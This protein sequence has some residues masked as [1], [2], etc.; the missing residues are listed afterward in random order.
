M[1]TTGGG[2][3][4]GD[5][6]HLRRRCRRCRRIVLASAIAIATVGL[7]LHAAIGAVS[8]TVVLASGPSGQ[9]NDVRLVAADSAAIVFS[10]ADPELAA[11]TTTYVQ[12]RTGPAHPLPARFRVT[13]A[14][15]PTLVGNM[16]GTY[17]PS[18]TLASNPGSFV[19]STVDGSVG[20][21]TAVASGEFQGTSADGYLYSALPDAPTDT[22]GGVH[23]YDVNLVS[24]TTTDLGAVPGNP[25]FLSAIASAAGV[26]LETKKTADSVELPSLYYV[27]Y[28]DPN[29][30]VQLAS[31]VAIQGAPVV[32]ANSV[33]WLENATV[34][35]DDQ[36]FD[37]TATRVVRVTLE[38]SAV[39]RR[40]APNAYEVAVTAAYTGVL[41][42]SPGDA[43]ASLS[44][45]AT[46]GG[47]PAAY[48]TPVGADLLSTGTAF[49]VTQ[50]GTPE[51]A[52]VYTLP[53]AVGPAVLRSAAGAATL[54]ASTISV[55]SAR[56]VWR[57]N[58]VG[59]GL[60]GR[61]L[62]TVQTTLAA[63]DPSVISSQPD[64][65]SEE[66]VSASGD[67]VAYVDG[68]NAGTTSSVWLAAAGQAPQSI[69][70]AAADDDLTLSG[71][72]L[73]QRHDDGSATLTDLG[74]G[75]ASVLPAP[76]EPWSGA[77]VGRTDYQL[78][79]NELAW[80]ASDGSVWFKDL[81]SG[82]SSE[83]SGPAV[84]AGEAVVG[85]VA[86]AA[87]IVAW[88][89]SICTATEGGNEAASNCKS[90]GLRYR[91]GVTLGETYT[92]PS[93]DPTRI[94][95]SNGYLAFDDNSNGSSWVDVT[96]LYSSVIERIA[97]LSS[98]GAGEAEF[99]ISGSMLGWIGADNLPHAATLPHVPA[100][101]WYLGNGAV[102]SSLVTDGAHRWEAAF[103]ASEVLTQCAVNI[104]LGHT[105]VRVLPCDTTQ[106]AAG[107][108]LVSWD[109]RNSKGFNVS[110]GTYTW[111]L[112]G[113]N[114]DG[115][116]LD[117]DGND[118][119]ITGTITTTPH[120]IVSLACTSSSG[121]A[122]KPV[123]LTATISGAGPGDV[124]FFDGQTTIGTS[125]V[126]GGIATLTTSTLGSA[127]HSIT[128]TFTPADHGPA[129]TSSPVVLLLS[130]SSSHV[131]VTVVEP[132][133]A[134]DT[135]TMT[136]AYTP[137]HPLELGALQ[138]DPA[139]NRL[140]TSV[141]FG[142]PTAA[143]VEVTDSRPGN[144]NWTVSVET[145]DFTN[146]AAHTVINSQNTGITGLTAATKANS[147][148][149][150]N[151]I[152]FTN[153]SPPAVPLA[154]GV[155]GSDGLGGEPHQLASTTNGGNGTIGFYGLFTLEAPTSTA[156]GAYQGT[157]VFTIG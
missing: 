84:A 6:L 43:A 153:V 23:I 53:S 17:V 155:V 37:P 108:A 31:S 124:A 19:Y 151:G 15:P 106:M 88:S 39:E 3:P 45:S 135:L 134:P 154:A 117:A 122:Y 127:A 28:A 148:L 141:T 103:F 138:L 83:I 96:P 139:A 38:G 4:N 34:Y 41:S 140:A 91:N 30:F 22:A 48:E 1:R 57:D 112:D 26:V 95:L 64:P 110:P 75:T 78:W 68:G 25:A 118:S 35:N 111:T 36:S 125:T 150:A 107:D 94:Q 85:S 54:R 32:G 55:S 47:Q 126:S 92:V 63:G 42:A 86:V 50:G 152:T 146:D 104:S 113:A 72:R 74:D 58:G 156:P 76:V 119:P 145:S 67:R 143:A 136:T 59:A 9:P 132:A 128:A 147:L 10:V 14:R 105:T 61:T 115:P 13:D 16:L 123:T 97:A 77:F 100:K 51:T 133:N 130:D 62:S 89:E 116:L 46:T 114:A 11:G 131:G 49:V 21:T 81:L 65:T 33:A 66:S 157:I 129:A 144:P 102:T 40:A 56:V 93:A 29:A 52:G 82:T 18:A 70:P 121:E 137:A 27:R 2:S 24:E 109:G 90:S 79:G 101:P 8:N 99:S 120:S 98:G 73:L 7:P 69:G 44:T 71:T 12:P 5:V 80:L 87:G 60:W 149:G 142:S 20:G